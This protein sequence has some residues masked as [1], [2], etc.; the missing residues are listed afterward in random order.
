MRKRLLTALLLPLLFA[1]CNDDDGGVYPCLAPSSP[2]LIVGT[3]AEE[4]TFTSPVLMTRIG[5]SP[6]TAE[7][8]ILTVTPTNFSGDSNDLI[9]SNRIRFSLFKRAHACSPSPISLLGTVRGIEITS[10]AD[11]NANYP[12]GSDL[13]PLFEVVYFGNIDGSDSAPA[14]ELDFWPKEF[15]RESLIQL[16]LTQ[17]PT[18]N[19]EHA[20]VIST[21]S[22]N[23]GTSFTVT[24]KEPQ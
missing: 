24:F 23:W 1:G 10:N 7:D 21:A 9:A 6:V 14:E 22:G 20:F 4:P 3:Q 11:F 17:A 13:S 12:A 5:S 8:L 2:A 15:T 16:R 19:N 18:A